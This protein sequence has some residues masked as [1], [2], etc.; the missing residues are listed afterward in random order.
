MTSAPMSLNKFTDTRT[1]ARNEFG[2]ELIS[3]DLN[4]AYPLHYSKYIHLLTMFEL[5]P[6]YI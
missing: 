1:P 6:S 4:Q 5:Y 2:I 3:V